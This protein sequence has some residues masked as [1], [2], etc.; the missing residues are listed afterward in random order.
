M[1]AELMFFE[2]LLK[3]LNSLAN[4]VK[5]ASRSSVRLG[6]LFAEPPLK[7]LALMFVPPKLVKRLSPGKSINVESP[8][9]RWLAH[10]VHP[11]SRLWNF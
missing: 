10:N 3:E 1:F 8:E 11:P 2:V 4:G 5:L 7:L 6:R 9:S